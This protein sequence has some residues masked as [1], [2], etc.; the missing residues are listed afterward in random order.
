[1]LHRE[2]ERVFCAGGAFAF[3]LLPAMANRLALAPTLVF[4]NAAWMRWG[5]IVYEL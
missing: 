2:R 3:S 5:G 4:W 1:M